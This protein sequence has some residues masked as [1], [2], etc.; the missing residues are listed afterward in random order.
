MRFDL[1]FYEKIIQPENNRR[2]KYKFE[3]W[4]QDKNIKYKSVLHKKLISIEEIEDVFTGIYMKVLGTHIQS[5]DGL[6]E[7]GHNGY[8]CCCNKCGLVQRTTF[9]YAKKKTVVCYGCFVER[10]YDEARERGLELIS[11]S[12]DG[13]KKRKHYKFPCGH[14]RDIAQGDVRIGAFSCTECRKENLQESLDKHSLELIGR[15]DKSMC[16][17][18]TQFYHVRYKSCGHDRI[19]TQQNLFFGS[20]GRCETC[21]EKELQAKYGEKWKVDILSKV[22]GARRE[23]RFRECGHEKIVSLSNLKYG[24]FE[25]YDC[26]VER[27]K[28]EAEESGLIYIGEDTGTGSGIKKKHLYRAPCNHI[29]S[30]KQSAVRVGHWTCRTCNSGYLDRFNYL[31][32]FKITATDGFEFLKFGY[33][34]KPEHRK[35]DYIVDKGTK[36]DLIRKVLVPTGRKV[37]ELENRIHKKL[38]EYN[39]DKVFMKRYLTESGFTECYPIGVLDNLMLELDLVENSLKE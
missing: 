11:S 7:A 17:D 9:Q 32:I 5:E 23:I 18:P 19:V 30:L 25:C 24:N 2:L 39:L 29:L 8:F 26:K 12:L 22:E 28:Q 34:M 37:I 13:D 20:V 35:Y 10:L 15:P 3:K 36:F 4:L 1:D 27:W 38:S 33:S 14:S 16:S 21:Y 31:Y 6:I